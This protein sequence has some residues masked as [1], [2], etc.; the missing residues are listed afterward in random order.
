MA[1][2]RAELLMK[3]FPQPAAHYR[4]SFMRA[5]ALL[6]ACCL[7]TALGFSN[8]SNEQN[9]WLHRCSGLMSGVG[10]TLMFFVAVIA[11]TRFVEWRQRLEVEEMLP[12]RLRRD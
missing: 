11:Y 12:V 4:T 8:L 3:I 10:S 1:D 2:V 6:T 5:V 9:E 7:L